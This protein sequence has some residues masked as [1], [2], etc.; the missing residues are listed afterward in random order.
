MWA[1]GYFCATVRNVDEETVR[2]YIENQGNEEYLL[3]VTLLA[4]FQ[5]GTRDGFSRKRA[6]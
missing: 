4:D 6:F 2:H 3:V 5:S 1:K